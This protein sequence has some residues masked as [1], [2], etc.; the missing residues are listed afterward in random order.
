M[1]EAI[2]EIQ[3]LEIPLEKYVLNIYSL[4]S[5]SDMREM[6][7]SIKRYHLSKQTLPL[8]KSMQASDLCST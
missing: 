7:K 4:I 5:L 6:L 8:W 1:D 2:S 3:E